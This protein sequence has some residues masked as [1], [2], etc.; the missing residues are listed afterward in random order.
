MTEGSVPEVMMEDGMLAV[1]ASPAT[2]RFPLVAEKVAAFHADPAEAAVVHTAS[3]LLRSKHEWRRE[4]ER[5]E[6][7]YFTNREGCENSGKSAWNRCRIFCQEMLTDP[8]GER[9]EQDGGLGQ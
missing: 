8:I 5:G 6:F 2:G 4:P 1:S 9:L 7:N 3:S